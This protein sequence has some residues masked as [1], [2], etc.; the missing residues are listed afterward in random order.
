MVKNKNKNKME[1]RKNYLGQESNTDHLNVQ[2]I[3]PET[4]TFGTSTMC[5]S[6]R[7]VRLIESQKRGVK[8]SRDHL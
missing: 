6:W 2:S 8:K 1:K 4:D 3:L 7:E 5:P